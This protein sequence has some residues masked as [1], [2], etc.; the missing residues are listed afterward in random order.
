MS[1]QKEEWRVEFF[2][3][4]N[5]RIPVQEYL[6]TLEDKYQ[7]KIIAHIELLRSKGGKLYEPY[8]KHIRGPL[9][10]LRVDFGRMATRIFY[11]LATGQRILLLHGFMKKTQKTPA[12]E[13]ERAQQYYSEYLQQKT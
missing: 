10:E 9:W 6:D 13:I 4:P 11:F 7:A 3:R 5:G 8:T 2:K 1:F 12:G